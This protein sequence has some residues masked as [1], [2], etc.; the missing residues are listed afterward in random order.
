VVYING[1]RAGSVWCPPYQLNIGGLL[2][3]GGNSIRVIVAN[4]AMNAMSAQRED[5]SRLNARY[6]ERFQAQDMDSIR[7]LPSGLLGPIQLILR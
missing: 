1:E 6:G 4:L 2:K 7:P 5:D 3:P